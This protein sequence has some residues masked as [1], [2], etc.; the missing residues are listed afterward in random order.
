MATEFC[1]RIA[2]ETTIAGNGHRLAPPQLHS[3]WQ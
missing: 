1:D 2:D 3:F